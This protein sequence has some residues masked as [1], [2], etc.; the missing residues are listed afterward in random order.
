MWALCGWPFVERRLVVGR[1]ASPRLLPV[2]LF[3]AAT[4]VSPDAMTTVLALL[5]ISS[6]LRMTADPSPTLPRAFLVEAVL[7]S[8]ALGL[9]KPSYVVVALCYLLPLLGP[10]RRRALAARRRCR[11]RSRR[12]GA[13]AHDPVASLRVR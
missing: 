4:S 3:Q 9:C 11:G 12:V 7:F 10:T 1:F 2:V 6:A 5:V 13:L 8:V